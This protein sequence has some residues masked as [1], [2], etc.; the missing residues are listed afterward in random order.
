V[1]DPETA[2]VR[3]LR[4]DPAGE[5]M[6]ALYRAHGGEL[7]GFAVNALGDSGRAEEVVQEVFT[8]AWQHAGRY[9]PARASVR[10][11]L[12]G[13]A[14]NAVIDARRRGAARPP[15]APADAPE[16]ASEDP[17]LDEALLRWQVSAALQQLSPAHRQVVR[18][19][20]FQGLSVR[21]AAHALG[22]P[23]GTVKS[24]TSYALRSLRLILDEMEAQ[25]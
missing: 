11:W 13:I 18:L 21:E 1:N 15:L 20:H 6:R 16:R 23:E 9:D 12:Y 8:R 22:I 4:H 5:A 24:R 7:Y 2:L 19:V 3:Q 17:S 10:T 14:R 25:P